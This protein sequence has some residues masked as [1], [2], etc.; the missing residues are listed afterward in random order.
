MLGPDR[1]VQPA[2]NLS[3]SGPRR[4]DAQASLPPCACWVAL[5]AAAL[6]ALALF[7]PSAALAAGCDK[8]E[9]KAGGSWYAAANWSAG[10]PEAGEEVCIQKAGTYEVEV[11]PTGSASSKWDR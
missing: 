7:A 5:A 2:P 11:E 10:V 6:S 3:V 4:P 1:R 9:N 8:W